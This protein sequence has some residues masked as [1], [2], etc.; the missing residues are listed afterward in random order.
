MQTETLEKIH[1]GHQ[2]S[3]KCKLRAKTCFLEWHKQRHRQDSAAMRHL[4]R[5]PEIPIC[6][7]PNATWDTSRTMA[8]R[9]YWYFQPQLAQLPPHCGLLFKIPLHGLSTTMDPTLALSS[10]K[11]LL[12]D[13]ILSTSPLLRNTPNQTAWQNSAY[14]PS[15]E[16][17]RRPY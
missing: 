4:S 17:W 7:V 1:Y 15:R 12:K 6:R 13:G 14:R 10:L 16:P 3:D 9:G 2:G 8:N 5:T 11:N